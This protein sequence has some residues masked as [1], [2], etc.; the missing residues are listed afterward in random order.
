MERISCIEK[1]CCQSSVRMTMIKQETSSSS[2]Y[3]PRFCIQTTN[4]QLW[5]QHITF[6]CIRTRDPTEKH[7]LIGG[8]GSHC[9]R[10]D[11]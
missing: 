5:H 7:V 10:C 6:E 2:G 4:Y 8:R 9:C 3:C 11:A 1:L